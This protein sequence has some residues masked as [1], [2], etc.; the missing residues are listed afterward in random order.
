MPPR[1]LQTPSGYLRSQG[2]DRVS[3]LV[4][5]AGFGLSIAGAVALA[6]KTS[7]DPTIQKSGVLHYVDVS[8]ILAIA[9]V[10]YAG[11]GT[12]VRRRVRATLR[13]GTLTCFASSCVPLILGSGLS[14]A[15]SYAVSLAILALILWSVRLGLGHTEHDGELRF[16]WPVFL[17]LAITAISTIYFGHTSP[18]EL[19]APWSLIALGGV[20]YV[21]PHRPWSHVAW[22]LLALSAIVAHYVTV[23]RLT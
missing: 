3:S 6:L 21:L 11:W 13:T 15:S 10:Y 7:H 9:T 23:W 1:W 12:W 18:W 5:S 22:H 4:L 20:A 16:I 17:M 19:A 8:L 2:E 14:L